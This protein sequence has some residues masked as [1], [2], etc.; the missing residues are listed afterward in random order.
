MNKIHLKDYNS[1][2]EIW[3]NDYSNTKNWELLKWKLHKSKWKLDKILK[4]LFWEV[5]I[6]IYTNYL[7]LLTPC[8][9]LTS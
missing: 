9:V 3:I 5:M 2:F 6:D 4:R 8:L 1:C 7:Y